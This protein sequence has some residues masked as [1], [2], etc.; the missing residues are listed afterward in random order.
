M[1]QASNTFQVRLEFFSGPMDL[2][3]HLV[4]QQEV[5]IENVKMAEVAEQYLQI[6][7]QQSKH[8]DL[9]RAS[10]FLVIA[11]TLLAI[12]SKSLLP[13]ENDENEAEDTEE[14]DISRFFES[15]RERLKVYQVTKERARALIQTPQLDVDI[16]ARRDHAACKPT[17][18][19]LRAP[20]DGLDL[21][22]LFGSLLKRIGE[23]G[24]KLRI[25]AEPVSV[26]DFMMRIL[27]KLSPTKIEGEI[28]SLV[29]QKPRGFFSLVSELIGGSPKKSKNSESQKEAVVK[30]SLI[31]GFVAVLELV[32]RGVVTVK[33]ESPN[34]DIDISLGIDTSQT[35]L[36]KQEL[37][38]A[39]Q[40]TSVYEPETLEDEG[41]YQEPEQVQAKAKD[42]EQLSDNVVQISDYKKENLESGRGVGSGSDHFDLTEQ[43]PSSEELREANKK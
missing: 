32:K 4:S 14:N 42:Q 34:S 43:N 8:L 31:A 28:D 16:F 17:P 20:E 18:E 6:V 30:G 36:S 37:A 40:I 3:L 22:I 12:K 27:D 29:S 41:N 25:I 19:M 21:G 5:A 26:I 35:E 33:Q 7:S 38:E 23:T 2:L 9:D 13:A 1:N 24:K 10:E 15:L 39:S 11:T